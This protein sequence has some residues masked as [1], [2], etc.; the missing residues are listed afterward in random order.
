M[1]Y[2]DLYPVTTKLE[3]VPATEVDRLA[4]DYELELPGG[5]RDF[6][7]RFGPGNVCGYLE[8]RHEGR[9]AAVVQPESH[10]RAPLRPNPALHLVG[11]CR[12][13]WSTPQQYA[14]WVL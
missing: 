6:L 13:L 14:W 8:I 5:Y 10:R 12:R 7:S 1:P 2:D 3:P 9:G 4:A 11:P